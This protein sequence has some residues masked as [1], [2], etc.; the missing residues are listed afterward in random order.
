MKLF[1]TLALILSVIFMSCQKEISY[2]DPNGTGGGTNTTTVGTKLIRIGSKSGSDT[3]T[4]EYTYN[5]ANRVTGFKVTGTSGGQQV[6]QSVDFV[7][8]S[9]N[10]ITQQVYKDV[11]LSQYGLTSITTNFTYDATASH[12]KYGLTTISVLGNTYK[13][14]VVYIYDASNNLTSS[15][16]YED[17]GTGY[18]PYT[19]DEYTYTGS[20]LGS[21]KSSTYNDTTST[22]V[23]DYTSSF[24]YDT[25]I[26]PLKF[27]A[28]APVL[29]MTTFYS[30]N[31]VTKETAVITSPSSTQSVTSS[32][33]YNSNNMP[34][35][36]TLISNSGTA[37]ATYYYQ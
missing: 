1:V 25:K 6:D 14:S 9:S 34:S 15:I 12:Y 21:M 8:N 33:T 35:I 18:S 29:G 13:D 20:N 7:R 28:D 5:S 24:E 4:T 23:V 30:A 36:G 3:T 19:K 17:A 16:D 31:N 10:V 22:Y 37:V 2:E 26:N 27:V 11:S 32:Y